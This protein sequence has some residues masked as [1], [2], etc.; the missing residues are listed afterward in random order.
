MHYRN[1][2]K[3]GFEVSTFG[4]GCMR[5]PQIAE[6]SP[7]VDR[8]KAYE[9]IRYAADNG[10]NY[11]DTAFIYHNMTSEEILGEALE[12]G[13]REKVKIATKLGF[14]RMETNDDIRKNLEE[15]LRRLRTN[16]IDVYLI[17]GIGPGNWEKIKQRKII[18]EYEQFR[19]EGLIRAIAFSYHGNFENFRD[20]L[21]FYDWGMCQVQHNFMDIE[22]EVTAKGIHHAGKKGCALV[23][24][25]GLRGG[26][27]ACPPPAVQEIYDE[28]PQKRSGVE[29]AFRYLLNFPEVSTILSGVSSLEQLKDNIAIFSKPDIHA[30]CLSETEMNIIKCVREKYTSLASIPC[31]GCG[32]CMPC[33]HGVSISGIFAK[34]NESIMF[35]T[36]EPTRRVYSFY[37][38]AKNDA[39]QCAK[40]GECEP[41]CPQNIAIIK[42]LHNAHEKLKGWVG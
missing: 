29:W 42:E 30:G 6:D 5:L 35:G 17:H 11:F 3:L 7:L 24:M 39:G 4:M 9:M 8:E 22:K 33:P 26:N 10:V 20:V 31:T 1:F 40:C 12:G 36:V 2:G 34:L 25:E 19:S 32:Y 38:N 23:V 15:A 37:T 16:Y 18:E 14:N 28:Y 21:D 13:R 27:L 41:K